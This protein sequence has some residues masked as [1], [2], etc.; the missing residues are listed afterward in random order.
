[1]GPSDLSAE[2]VDETKDIQLP[3]SSRWFV[4]LQLCV[5]VLLLT[6][7]WL[8]WRWD[9]PIRSLV[10]KEDWWTWLIE[11]YSKLSWADFANQSDAYITTGLA[12]LGIGLMIL[13]VVPWFVR[14]PYCPRIAWLLL[15]ATVVLGLDGFAR[16]MSRDYELGMGLEHSLQIGAPMLL[17]VAARRPEKMKLWLRVASALTALTFVGHGLYA[18]GFHTVPLNFKLMT[19]GI[20]PLSAEG[21]VTLLLVAGWLDLVCAVGLFIRPLRV[22]SLIYMIVWGGLTALARAVAYFDPSAKGMGL[23]PWVFETLVR[24]P[25]W[26]IPALILA[27]ITGSIRCRG[28]GGERA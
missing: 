25:H 5:S 22:P 27:L 16:F 13:G 2:M 3:V 26:L 6:R 18:I 20:L 9:S 24:T 21:T 14:K 10:W 28:T 4:A 8:T 23:D 17:F 7:G 1:M 12:W 15:P 19:Q 11:K